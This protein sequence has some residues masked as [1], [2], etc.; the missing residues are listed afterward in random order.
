[1]GEQI[2]SHPSFHPFLSFLPEAAGGGAVKCRTVV[3]Q[4]AIEV[5][6]DVGLE[7]VGEPLEHH[8]HVDPVRVRPGVLQNPEETNQNDIRTQYVHMLIGKPT[9]PIKMTIFVMSTFHEH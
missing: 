4:I 5:N 2:C 7:A 8:V 9:G 3:E 6:T 1:M